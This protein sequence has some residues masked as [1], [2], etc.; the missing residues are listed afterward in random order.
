MSDGGSNFSQ[1]CEK[2]LLE[3]LFDIDPAEVRR[4]I[5]SA[6]ENNIAL[7]V[8]GSVAGEPFAGIGPPPARGHSVLHD[9]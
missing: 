4:N 8:A 7:P 9:A 5:A 6:D 2:P 1:V 3:P